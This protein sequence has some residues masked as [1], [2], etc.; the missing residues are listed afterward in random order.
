MSETQAG[1]LAESPAVGCY[2]FFGSMRK[3]EGDFRMIWERG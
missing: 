3:R 1:I 2:L